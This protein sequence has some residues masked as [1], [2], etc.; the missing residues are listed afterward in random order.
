MDAF[1]F[2][3]VGGGSAGS[4][5]AWRLAEARASVCVVEAGP[6][7]SSPWIRIPAGFIKTL[8][9]PR[10]TWQFRSEPSVGTAGRAIALPQGRTLGGSSSI[11]GA[12]FS[13]GHA[14][15]FDHWSALGNKG[16]SFAEVL[17]Y[18]KRMEDW[19]GE[20]QGPM[21]GTGGRL[22]VSE[23]RMPVPATEA[24]ILACVEAGLPRNPDH[25]SGRQFGVGRSQGVIRN[26]WRVSAARAFLHPAKRRPAAAIVTRT[27]ATRIA[28]EDGRAV[29]VVVRR[30][31]AE[32]E[33]CITA[34]RGVVL[35]AGAVGS[36]KLLQLSGIGPVALLHSRGIEVRHELPGVGENLRDHYTARLVAR[37]RPGMDG[38]NNRVRGWRLMLEIGRWLA[39]RPSALGI[40]PAH[41][42]VFGKSQS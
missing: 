16:W 6:P 4:L 15:D 12:V 29:G 19:L 35:A 34:R 30:E 42:H 17:P 1:D 37:G 33:Q 28:V 10:L 38:I 14:A 20:P 7:D 24:F 40:S 27:T 5:L 25:N 26:G 39:G 11:N 32:G 23:N 8:N 31:G 36:P 2:V 21:R 13:R 41:V 3:I 18:F 22:P 9:D